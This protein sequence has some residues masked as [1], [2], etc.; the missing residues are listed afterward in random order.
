MVE[1]LVSGCSSPSR[2]RDAVLTVLKCSRTAE[3][4]MNEL[5]AKME[6]TL[7]TVNKAFKVEMMKMPPSLLNTRIGDLISGGFLSVLFSP[8][9]TLILVSKEEE[10]FSRRKASITPKAGR[11]AKTLATSSSTGNLRSVVSTGDLHGTVAAS[12]TRISVTTAQ[13]QVQIWLEMIDIWE[14]KDE[15]N[16][17]LL[18]DVAWRQVQ[19]LKSLVE[20]VSRRRCQR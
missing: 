14:T 13:G 7:V 17:D 18:D 19:K 15:V 8:L 16:L 6:N 9:T 5:E 2:A 11:A 3:E 10:L 4:H 12:A 20:H 1:S